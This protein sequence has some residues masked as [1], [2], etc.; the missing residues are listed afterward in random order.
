LNFLAHAYL[1]F[2]DPQILAGNMIS[3]FVKGRSKFSYPERIQQGMTLH[4]AID[5]FTD[6]H[7]A[8]AEAKSFFRPHYRLYSGPIVDVLYDHF[9]A[10][11]VSLFTEQ[12][13]KTFSVGVYETL[14]QQVVHLPQNFVY[15]LPYMKSEDWLF[16]YRYEEGIAR[17]LRGL[18]RRSAF[19]TEHQTAVAL[20]QKHFKELEACYALFF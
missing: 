12:S 5:A 13:L 16:N 10:N 8:T 11:D 19:M 17:T 2:S 14:E 3:D 6:A 15:L 7:P 4:R 20:F 9:L 1:S 18:V